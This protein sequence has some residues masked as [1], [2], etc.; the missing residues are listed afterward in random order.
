LPFPIDDD[1][2]K[3]LPKLAGIGNSFSYKEGIVKTDYRKEI[4]VYNSSWILEHSK[5]LQN[6]ETKNKEAAVNV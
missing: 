1:I 5:L 6:L 3:E 2:L 4:S